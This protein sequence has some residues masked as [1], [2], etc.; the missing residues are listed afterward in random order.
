MMQELRQRG[1][2]RPI[3]IN[4]KFDKEAR[5]VAQST[6]FDSGQVYLP[7]NAPWLTTYESELLAFPNGRH[8]DQVDSTSQALLWLTAKTTRR[9]PIERRNPTRRNIKRA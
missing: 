1:P 8:D 5:L 3:L 6:R 4:P 2:V 9:E 7:K